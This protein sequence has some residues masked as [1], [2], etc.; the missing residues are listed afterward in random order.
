MCGAVQGYVDV[1]RTFERESGTAPGVD[2]DQVGANARHL[3]WLLLPLL[4]FCRPAL[5]L[6]LACEP[7]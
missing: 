1:A 3:L 5:L 4:S 6:R 2:L 7:R